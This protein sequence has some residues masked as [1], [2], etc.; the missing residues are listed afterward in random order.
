MKPV[1][2]TAARDLGQRSGA[3]ALV[4]VAVGDDGSYSVTTWGRTRREC[5]ALKDYTESGGF[6]GTAMDVSEVVS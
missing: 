2:V 4:I 3:L 6:E 1:S 5:G